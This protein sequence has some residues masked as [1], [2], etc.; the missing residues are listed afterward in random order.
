MTI[1]L[2]SIFLPYLDV[3]RWVTTVLS[4]VLFISGL[5]FFYKIFKYKPT[6]ADNDEKARNEYIATLISGKK[7]IS[8]KD[9]VDSS[10]VADNI[11]LVNKSQ[12]DNQFIE[13]MKDAYRFYGFIIDPFLTDMFDEQNQEIFD[14]SHKM[15]KFLSKR[16]TAEQIR[17]YLIDKYTLDVNNGGHDQWLFNYSGLMWEETL[18]A[19]K[20][21]GL[22]EN[23]KI[24]N[25]FLEKALKGKKYKTRQ[26]LVS[27]ITDKVPAED[28]IIKTG[29]LCNKLE[30]SSYLDERFYATDMTGVVNKYIDNNLPKFVYSVS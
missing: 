23:Y 26:E 2:L 22:E 20:H 25:E 24:L 15:H 19:L 30:D 3:P 9:L 1:S 17:V 29:D 18:E 16:L 7:Q 5:L 12:I 27:L 11:K 8:K 14:N 13:K 28:K 4:I 10:F 6:K 21:L